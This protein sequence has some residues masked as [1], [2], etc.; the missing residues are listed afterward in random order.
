MRVNR[1]GRIIRDAHQNR[2]NRKQFFNKSKIIPN[3]LLKHQKVC[4]CISAKR[5]FNEKKREVKTVYSVYDIANWFLS[6]K[7]MSHKKLQKMCYYAQAWSYALYNRPLMDTEFQ[8]WVHGPVSPQLYQK[9]KGHGFQ[10]LYCDGDLHISLSEEDRELLESVMLT[11]GDYTGNALEALTHTEL[12]WIE[13]RGNL[14]NSENCDNVIS[15]ATMRSFYQSIY[16][17]GDA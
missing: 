8:A 15:A 2:I 4:Y 17:G 3:S 1:R 12:P 16:A 14:S 11:Y 13:A 5:L 7:T 6:Q 9:Y 10:D